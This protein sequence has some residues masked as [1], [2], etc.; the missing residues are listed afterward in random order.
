MHYSGLVLLF[1]VLCSIVLFV[2]WGRAKCLLKVTPV[3]YAERADIQDCVLIVECSRVASQVLND[4][5]NRIILD[6]LL[7]PEIS[8]INFSILGI[9]K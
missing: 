4:I 1:Y 6:Y 7:P 3:F 9:S 5:P 8:E 2:A